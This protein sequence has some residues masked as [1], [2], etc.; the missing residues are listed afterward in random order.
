LAKKQQLKVTSTKK[1]RFAFFR[2]FLD[3]MKKVTWPSRRET[4]R[5]TLMVIVVCAVVGLILGSIDYGF[6]E[7]V[8]KVFLGGG[9]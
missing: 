2:D 7:L 6:S 9:V 5:L 3:E 1:S 8:S 4:I